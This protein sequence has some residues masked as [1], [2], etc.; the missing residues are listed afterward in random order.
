MEAGKEFG[1]VRRPGEIGRKKGWRHRGSDGGWVGGR[2][3]K[4]HGNLLASV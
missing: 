3:L 2:Y 4:F 1:Y